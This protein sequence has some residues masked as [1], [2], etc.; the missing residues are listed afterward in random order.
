MDVLNILYHCQTGKFIQKVNQI[1]TELKV[2]KHLVRFS[3]LGL[4]EQEKCTNL[5]KHLSGFSLIKEPHD[6]SCI[7]PLSHNVNTKQNIAVTVELHN[8]TA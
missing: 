6:D 1:I 8:S 4:I 5:T 7:L 2:S 3:L